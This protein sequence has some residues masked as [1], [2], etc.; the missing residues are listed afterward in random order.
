M[1]GQAHCRAAASLAGPRPPGGT[2]K[3][4]GFDGI[5]LLTP[6]A[7]QAGRCC[8]SAGRWPVLSG[9]GMAGTRPWSRSWTVG[10][11]NS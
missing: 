4:E 7:A 3:R 2:V 9:L 6:T 11:I 10:S 1:N 8:G 5:V